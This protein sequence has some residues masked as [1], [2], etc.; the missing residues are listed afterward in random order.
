VQRS[1][2]AYP[3]KG[4][5]FD[6]RRRQTTA[7]CHRAPGLQARPGRVAACRAVGAT[8]GLDRLCARRCCSVVGTKEACGGRTKEGTSDILL[9]RAPQTRNFVYLCHLSALIISRKLVK[10]A[11]G[12]IGQ[13][14][15]SLLGGLIVTSL[16]LAAF[17]RADTNERRLFYIFIDE[18]QNSRRSRWPT[19]SRSSENTGSVLY[20][21]T[22][23]SPNSIR[24]SR[25]RS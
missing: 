22:N 14:S 17:S 9:Y 25:Q 3:H 7:S 18:F 24:R 20:S 8:A 10:L 2:I 6:D 21:L 23:I 12:K 19:C 15:S 1:S 11:K 5:R 4:K 16:G 13:D